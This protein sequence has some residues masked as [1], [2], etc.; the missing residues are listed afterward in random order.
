MKTIW[1]IARKE[2]VQMLRSQR[3]LLWLRPSAAYCRRSV[4]FW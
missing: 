1:T 2:S 3:G 4:C